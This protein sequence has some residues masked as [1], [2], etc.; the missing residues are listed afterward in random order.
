VDG[1]LMAKEKKCKSCGEKFIPYR[2]DQ[3]CCSVQCGIEYAKKNRAKREAAKRKETR[4]NIREYKKNNDTKTLKQKAQDAVN[5]YVRLR[6][7]GNACIS[8]GKY[9]EVFENSKEIMMPAGD[10]GHFY[11]AGKYSSVRFNVNNIHLECQY[12]NRYSEIHL[13]GYKE[14]LIKKIGIERF[15]TLTQESKKS[16]RYTAYY[17]NRLIEI[18][19][20]KIKKLEKIK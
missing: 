7:R 9:I 13:I 14:N 18:A 3:V 2:N 10:A 8:C 11:S 5:R 16:R 1:N 17:Y 6:D 15:N 19:N 20:R 12:C 4:K